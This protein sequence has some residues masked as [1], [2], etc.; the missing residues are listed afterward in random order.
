VFSSAGKTNL[1]QTFY[2]HDDLL[3]SIET[4]SDSSGRGIER[5]SYNPFGIKRSQMPASG[6]PDV[7]LGFT[8]AEED[9]E[10]G[11][12]NLV[13]RIYD[14]QIGRSLS[15]D[16][17][18]RH[19]YSG[20]SFNRY[21]YVLNNPFT[22]TDPSGFQD[23]EEETSPPTQSESFPPSIILG[24]VGEEDT[25][26]PTREANFSP[27]TIIGTPTTAPAP[28]T[29]ADDQGTH[30]AGAPSLNPNPRVPL[31]PL[32]KPLAFQ[33]GTELA[34]TGYERGN[35]AS[36]ARQNAGML[37]QQFQSGELTSREMADKA[38]QLRRNLEIETRNNLPSWASQASGARN[39]QQYRDPYGPATLDQARVRRGGG[40]PKTDLE[41]TDASGLSLRTFVSHP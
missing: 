22:L 16:P 13:G 2:F 37:K 32:F 41:V 12:V 10:F 28:P 31:A 23:D 3:G 20:Q 8:G 5:F 34:R 19:L 1:N 6:Q 24:K 38:V 9:K 40:P 15:S 29:T 11:L 18:V 39:L 27:A 33:Q 17:I 30:G 14:P 35:Y 36:S 26:Q 21:S 4:V 25:S 7:Q